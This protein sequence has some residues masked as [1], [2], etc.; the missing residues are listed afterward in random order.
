MTIFLLIT[1]IAVFL[2]LELFGDTESAQY[3]IE[4]G[5]LYPPLVLN[6]GEIWRLFTPMFLHFGFRHLLNNMV[7]LVCSG[8]LLE[9]A[10]GKVKFLLL[11]LLAGIGGN[12]ISLLEMHYSQDY[13]AVA[14]ASG[15]IFGIIGALLWVVI[16]N[17]GSYEGITTK[18]MLFMICICLLYGILTTGV[19]NW[20]HFGGLVVGFL[21]CMIFYRRKCK[22]VDF[23]E[24]NQYT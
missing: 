20:G 16:C 15:A 9:K 14:G 19:D 23:T 13:A 18:R 8:Q 6:S 4:H 21:V 24:E 5:A 2:L 11:Y 17:R 7:I 1:N 22:K 3:M 10:L 12:I